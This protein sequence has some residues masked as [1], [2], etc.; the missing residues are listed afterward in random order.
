[1]GAAWDEVNLEVLRGLAAGR[2]VRLKRF[3][4]VPSRNMPSGG[5]R[6]TGHGTRSR[7]PHG[8]KGKK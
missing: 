3:R 7:A 2:D 4:K 8:V 5:P 6:P 1:M